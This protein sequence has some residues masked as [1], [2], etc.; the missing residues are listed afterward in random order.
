MTVF[1]GSK[2]TTFVDAH[3]HIDL[4]TP[5]K[6]IIEQAESNHIY[7]IAVTNAPSVFA[8]TEALTVGSKYVRPAIGLHPELVH[9]HKYELSM[10]PEY[11]SRTRYV[12]EVGLDYS[13]KDADDRSAQRLVLSKIASWVN[14]FG[15]KVLTVHSRRASADVI[16]ILAGIK[17]KVILHWFSGTTK[18]LTH[19]IDSGFYFSVNGAMVQSKAGRLLIDNMPRDRFLTETDG[20]FTQDGGVPAT[21]ETVKDT[22]L[23]LSGLWSCSPHDAQTTILENFKLLLSADSL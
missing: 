5:P 18:D 23:K 20:P 6:R 17:A 13:T 3:C 4:Y 7:T 12:G 19:A 8:H 21:P 11:L 9:S 10:F 1:P 16:S 14:D 15:D 2:M 22:V